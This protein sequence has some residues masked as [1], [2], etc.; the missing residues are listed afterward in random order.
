M[1]SVRGECQ[2]TR[3]HLTW[4]GVSNAVTIEHDHVLLLSKFYE[5]VCSVVGYMLVR[6]MV[7]DTTT[8]RFEIW[9]KI[10]KLTK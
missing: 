2:L 7:Q 6:V 4:A 3:V 9:F 1:S 10:F 8:M 5:H